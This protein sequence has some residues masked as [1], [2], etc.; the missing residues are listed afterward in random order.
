MS[1]TGF[2]RQ[3]LKMLV[4]SINC[5]DGTYRRVGA[6]WWG[7]S[8]F[9]SPWEG[10][11]KKRKSEFDHIE[12]LEYIASKRG[13]FAPVSDILDFLLEKKES[14]VELTDYQCFRLEFRYILDSIFGLKY[15]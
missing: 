9:D 7:V 2:R 11:C 13:W 14:S 12:I 8:D 6:E 10:V 4:P 15:H 1:I 3:M 5:H